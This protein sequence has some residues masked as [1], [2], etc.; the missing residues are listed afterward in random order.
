M[1]LEIRRTLAWEQ[2]TF[3]EGWKKVD[4]PTGLVA[5]MMIIKNP[6]FGR[7][8]VENLRPEILEHGPVI[9]KMLTEML[10]DAVGDQLEGCGKSSVVGMGGEI[11]HA[12]AM[13]HT[14][15][16]GNQFREAIGA[17][18]YLAFSNTRG[19]AN[20]AITIPLMD[21]HDGGRR[22]HYQTIQTS[23]ADAPADDEIIIALGASIGG[24]P[25]HRI[26]DRYEDLRD[27]GRDF[28]NPAGV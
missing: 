14:L 8:H 4:E 18:S 27:M 6:W 3:I 26:G 19:S 23:I 13:T 17:K 25:N 21:K 1:L 20:C 11:E 15:H 12:Q 2:K 7:D 28:D 22:S 16:F 10:L 5:A 24:H 9:G